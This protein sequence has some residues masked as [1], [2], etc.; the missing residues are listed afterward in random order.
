MSDSAMKSFAS[1]SVV[2][3]MCL[4]A[5]GA[6]SQ[7]A[8]AQDR[9]YR[10]GNEYT[11]DPGDAKAR[12]CRLVEGGNVTVIQGLKPAPAAGTPARTSPPAT[13]SGA[14]NDNERVD[15][16]AQRARD[17][18]ARAILE[19]ELRKAESRLS[20]LKQEYNNGEPEKRGPEFRNHQMYLDRV[21]E[22]KAGVTRAQSDV[23]GIKRELARLGPASAAAR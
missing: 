19:A 14:R 7:T 23:D 3:L 8:A 11:N 9:I 5:L 22:L 20:G 4:L 16:N 17:A 2:H 1:A 15:A 10:C 13:S 18:D 12:G 21:S 6:L